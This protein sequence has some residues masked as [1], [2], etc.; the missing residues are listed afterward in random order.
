MDTLITVTRTRMR[1]VTTLNTIP[2]IVKQII[3]RSAFHLSALDFVRSAPIFHGVCSF[4]LL[5]GLGNFVGRSVERERERERET[6]QHSTQPA[7]TYINQHTHTR[8]EEAYSCISPC[9]YIY[10]ILIAS[11]RLASRLSVGLNSAPTQR[12]SSNPTP[13][14]SHYHNH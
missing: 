4:C 13:P 7:H 1:R 2:I 5:V 3:R 11:P 10:F 9:P 12:R 8:K 14:Q 6:R